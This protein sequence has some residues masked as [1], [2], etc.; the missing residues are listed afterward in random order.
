M[1][2][3][4][5]AGTQKIS[6]VFRQFAVN[7][8]NTFTNLIAQK[9]TDQLFDAA[10]VNKAIDQMVGYVTSGVASIVKRFVAGNTAKLTSDKATAATEKT[11]QASAAATSEAATGAA[12]AAHV[13]GEEAKAAAS[14]E[15]G[16]T[17]DAVAIS[18]SA[19]SIAS[20]GESAIA[21]IASKAWEAAANVYSS[22][23][24]IPYVGPFLAPAAAIAAGGV[25]LG[26]ASRIKSSAGG[27]T[28][29]S[30]DGLRFVHKDETI[31][32]R[33]YAAGLRD[34]IKKINLPTA[35]PSGV[36][37]VRNINLPTA[38]PS[39]VSAVR[40]INSGASLSESQVSAAHGALKAGDQ[41]NFS[42]TG[43]DGDSAK[44]FI[45]GNAKHIASA[46]RKNAR[47][48]VPITGGNT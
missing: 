19:T 46:M 10:G 34:A 8:A 25:V 9:F 27:D 32:S 33:D 40:N 15:S 30:E 18:S 26:F 20:T 43:V 3:G 17:Q 36:S 11:I 2:N 45:M 16:A 6:D 37:A 35:L 7:V 5:L 24:A 22:I 44:K 29:V 4:L 47:D 42:F 41:Y 12:V 38:L 1:I 31:L 39:S 13:T 48:F 23:A 21:N 28:Q 14:V